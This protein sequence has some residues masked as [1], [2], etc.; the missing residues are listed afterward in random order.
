M[1][2]FKK[3]KNTINSKV[4]FN[5]ISFILLLVFSYLLY[6]EIELIQSD[7]ENTN[8]IVKLIV[9]S[10][11]NLLIIFIQSYTLTK[12][13]K[14]RDMYGNLLLMDEEEEKEPEKLDTDGQRLLMTKY[15]DRLAYQS[16]IKRPLISK[17]PKCKF[18]ITSNMK[19]CPNCG[20]KLFL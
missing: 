2:Q 10:S 11:V 3:K 9:Y 5:I 12:N 17:C 20:L 13:K 1:S 8:N 6:K 18:L 15:E 7:P 14:K 19:K 4:F 16:A